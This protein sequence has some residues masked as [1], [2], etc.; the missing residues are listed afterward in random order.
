MKILLHVCCGPC[1]IYSIKKLREKY[2]NVE[3]FFYN[4]NIHP[5]SEYEKRRDSCVKL[6]DILNI[7]THFH[8]DLNFEDFFRKI[9]F[10][11]QDQRCDIC[12]GLRLKET[13]EYASKN[14]FCGFTSTLFISPYQDHEKLKKIAMDA[15]QQYKIAFIYEDFRPGFRQ[16]HQLS[17]DMGLYHQ[18][19]CGC[20]Y[21]ER[22]RFIKTQDTQTLKT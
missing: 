3:C 6:S 9:T 8:K 15:Q 4:P 12:W 14:G 11:E 7:K 16:S 10:Y 21:S 1:A 18:K 17:R 2:D 20:I 22:E 5:V 19:Y 13:A